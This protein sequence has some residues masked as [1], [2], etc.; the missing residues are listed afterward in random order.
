LIN[1]PFVAGEDAGTFEPHTH[2]VDS[3]VVLTNLKPLGR[4]VPCEAI[5]ADF[6][7]IRSHLLD[8]LDDAQ[9]SALLKDVACECVTQRRTMQPRQL[10]CE[11]G[12][13]VLASF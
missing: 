9:T 8:A 10:F 7:A 5:G 1:R 4:Q 12:R 6:E 3:S 11:I 13:G 2:A